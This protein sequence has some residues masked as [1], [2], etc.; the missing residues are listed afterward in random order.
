MGLARAVGVGQRSVPASQDSLPAA[1]RRLEL[2]AAAVLVDP[3]HSATVLAW[4]TEV[5]G[6]AA[7]QADVLVDAATRRTGPEI[8]VA[9]THVAHE[10]TAAATVLPTLLGPSRTWATGPRHP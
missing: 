8:T 7:A 10:L 4:C 5:A 1:V 3:A 2:R 9:A 6:P